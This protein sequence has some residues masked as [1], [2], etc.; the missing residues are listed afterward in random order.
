MPEKKP[1]NNTETMDHISVI[2]KY[3]NELEKQNTKLKA[4]LEKLTEA[5]DT[6]KQKIEE[7]NISAKQIQELLAQAENRQML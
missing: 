6:T 4:N 7:I 1:K 2:S 3:I 5:N